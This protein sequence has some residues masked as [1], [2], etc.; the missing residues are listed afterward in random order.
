[1][2]RNRK[3]ICREEPWARTSRYHCKLQIIKK[4]PTERSRGAR[5][6]KAC[7]PGGRASERESD[8]LSDLSPWWFSDTSPS[9]CCIL[10]I[11]P[12]HLHVQADKHFTVKAKRAPPWVVCFLGD[13]S[14]PGAIMKLVRSGQMTGFLKGSFHGTF[15]ITQRN[16]RSE[17]RLKAT[18][19]QM[20]TEWRTRLF[21]VG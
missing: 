12:S 10:T 1:M 5:G 2:G 19:V 17:N 9:L 13:I 21:G 8:P 16:H 6:Q 15:L 4:K 14:L 18:Q 7:H 11:K 20:P 3:H